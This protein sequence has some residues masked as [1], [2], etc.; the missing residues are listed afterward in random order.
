MSVFGKWEILTKIKRYLRRRN[1]ESVQLSKVEMDL[2]GAG[3]ATWKP[4]RVQQDAAWE[5]YVELV[6]RIALQPLDKGEGLLREA[7][8]SLHV[9]FGETRRILREGG[10]RVAIPLDDGNDDPTFGQAAVR[11]LNDILRPFLSKWHPLLEEYEEQRG[12]GVS[13]LEHEMQWER[14]DELHEELHE[15]QKKLKHYADILAEACGIQRIHR[16]D[17]D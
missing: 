14:Y 6:T 4:D 15:V 11:I 9:L 1:V 12:E 10:P 8:S 7:L 13:R 16:R 17:D 5:M 3:K 2:F